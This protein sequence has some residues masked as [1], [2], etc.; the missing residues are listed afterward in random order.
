MF[1]PQ[2]QNNLLFCV[3]MCWRGGLVQLSGMTISRRKK[4]TTCSL[5]NVLV[6]LFRLHIIVLFSFFLITCRSLICQINTFPLNVPFKCVR[7]CVC[8]S[9]CVNVCVKVCL[10]ACVCECVCVR[11]CARACVCAQT[12][13]LSRTLP[14]PPP[15]HTHTQ[16]H[17]RSL[18]HKAKQTFRWIVLLLYLFSPHSFQWL[19]STQRASTV[20]IFVLV[21]H[22]SS[23]GRTVKL[24]TASNAQQTW[25]SSC[26]NDAFEAHN[27]LLSDIFKYTQILKSKC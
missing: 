1:S 19:I 18:T 15:P 14:P 13:T 7:A 11:A 21:Q 17:T 25:H 27:Y 24:T 9:A 12:W 20:W 8:V 3:C 23:T 6:P 5:H 16:T 10:R 4:P 22:S 26:Q 2:T